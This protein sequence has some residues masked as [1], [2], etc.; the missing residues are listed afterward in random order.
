MAQMT[1]SRFI[2]G[3]NVAHALAISQSHYLYRPDADKD[4][5]LYE[6]C[7]GTANAS[8]YVKNKT[9]KATALQVR[10]KPESRKERLCLLPEIFLR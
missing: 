6:N 2:S 9:C 10:K 1:K 7:F 5:S 3:L 4:I 8:E